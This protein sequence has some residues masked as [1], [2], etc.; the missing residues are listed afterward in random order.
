[1]YNIEEYCD[2]LS[3][4]ASLLDCNKFPNVSISIKTFHVRNATSIANVDG[5]DLSGVGDPHVIAGLLKLFLRKQAETPLN[6][7]K[8][9]GEIF[10]C[11]T[12]N[13]D[14]C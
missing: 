5:A 6:F 1:M 11:N 2:P 13:K 8:V 10:S 7:A 14:T 9:S 3:P 4:M 12:Y